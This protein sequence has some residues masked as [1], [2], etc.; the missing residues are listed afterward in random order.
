M[1]TDDFAS[2]EFYHLLA[3][4]MFDFFVSCPALW[5][6]EYAEFY[7]WTTLWQRLNSNNNLL[8]WW[9]P[10]FLLS[11]CWRLRRRTLWEVVIFPSK[12]SVTLHYLNCLMWPDENIGVNTALDLKFHLWKP[13]GVAA[14]KSDLTAVMIHCV[15]KW[16]ELKKFWLQMLNKELGGSR[17]IQ[18]LPVDW[19][20]TTTQVKCTLIMMKHYWIDGNYL[21]MIYSWSALMLGGIYLCS[22]HYST[23]VRHTGSVAFHLFSSIVLLSLAWS[24]TWILLLIY[25]IT[26]IVHA[27]VSVS[28]IVKLSWFILHIATN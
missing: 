18:G 19:H 7:L 20:I 17:I 26:I 27:S 24:V 13:K 28:P 23:W 25:N 2:K 14:N 3:V 4:C 5:A 22:S 9:W 15:H 16:L 10:V 8:T 21:S 6:V 12:R 11:L 1:R